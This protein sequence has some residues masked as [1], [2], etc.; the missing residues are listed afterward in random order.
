MR[1]AV[2]PWL[3]AGSL[4]LLG[5]GIGLWLLPD[6]FGD[7]TL[8]IV[9][10]LLGIV[11]CLASRLLRSAPPY[12]ESADIR[13]LPHDRR[14]ELIR[15]TG[16]FL[17]D[18][19]FRYSV[20]LDRT[21]AARAREFNAEVNQVRLGFLPAVITDNAS[22]RE[23]PGYVA[24]VYDGRRWRGPGLPCP[25]GQTEA[26]RHAARCVS[27]LAGEDDGDTRIE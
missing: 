12:R 25:N 9:L 22:D 1:D 10:V 14:G 5:M 6:E 20:R 11:G 4:V 7:P 21:A 2:R 16:M 18:S 19:R 27:P 3:L 23:G 15:G 26:V 24:F 17:R 13:D 8:A